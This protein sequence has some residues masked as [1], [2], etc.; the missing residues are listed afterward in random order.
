MV[1][2]VNNIKSMLLTQIILSILITPQ[3][4]IAPNTCSIHRP[5]SFHV[6]SCL[7][8]KLQNAT[9]NVDDSSVEVKVVMTLCLF[10]KTNVFRLVSL[11]VPYN[12]Q[13][14]CGQ[15]F[16]MKV[17]AVIVWHPENRQIREA[18]AMV[19]GPFVALQAVHNG[20]WVRD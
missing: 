2:Y 20:S 10:Y 15:H 6:L 3:I 12:R 17:L 18:H 14:L 1:F 9:Q 4:Y 11:K 5:L 8:L 13:I 19:I 7:L 16:C